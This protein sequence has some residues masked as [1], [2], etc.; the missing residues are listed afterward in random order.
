MSTYYVSGQ[1]RG[2]ATLEQAAR[3]AGRDYGGITVVPAN[4]EARAM[5]GEEMSRAASA[6]NIDWTRPYE[7][8]PTDD[9]GIAARLNAPSI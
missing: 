2:Y 6:A 3:V 7:A 5:T 8:P 4:G 9:A 1:G